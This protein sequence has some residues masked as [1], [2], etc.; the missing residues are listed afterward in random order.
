MT[1]FIGKT[2]YSLRDPDADRF[3]QYEVDTLVFHVPNSSIEWKELWYISASGD[4]IQTG[5]KNWEN[6]KEIDN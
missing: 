5:N 1:L 4:V 6:L 3:I 2:L